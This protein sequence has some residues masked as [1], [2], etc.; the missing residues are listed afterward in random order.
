MSRI[1]EVSSNMDN[2]SECNVVVV[3]DKG[4]GKSALIGQF[5]SGYYEVCMILYLKSLYCF[6]FS[7]VFSF[8][9]CRI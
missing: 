9:E 5:C 7:G 3:G 2:M 1:E 8:A 4:V 6:L